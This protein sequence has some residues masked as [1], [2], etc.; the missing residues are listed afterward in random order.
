[1]T[2]R[3]FLS[4]S[5]ILPIRFSALDYYYYQWRSRSNRHSSLNSY[6]TPTIFRV[7][8]LPTPPHSYF[9]GMNYGKRGEGEGK[10]Y[11]DVFSSENNEILAISQSPRALIS[12][13][14]LMST[15]FSKVC[16]NFQSFFFG[17]KVKRFAYI[18]VRFS[19]SVSFSISGRP[20]HPNLLAKSR[21][22][23]REMDERG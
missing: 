7:P 8:K 10:R 1:M 14:W 5:F 20:S 6:F 13:V 16:S 3:A 22:S 2:E 21:A 15:R 4:L 18:P 9:V 17:K 12:I 23:L 11:F 19:N